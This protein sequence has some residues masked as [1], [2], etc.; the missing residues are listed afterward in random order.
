[1]YHGRFRFPGCR[2]DSPAHVYAYSFNPNPQ[3]SNVY[4][5][6]AEILEYLKDTARN[7]DCS[8]LTADDKRVNSA[9]W[10]EKRGQWQLALLAVRTGLEL[11]DSCHI[12]LNAS[13]V[14]CST[15]SFLPPLSS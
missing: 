4:A 7:Y 2:C 13:G 3:W 8:N 12:L 14:L 6:A 9:I 1:M 15:F 5:P 11:D 10:S